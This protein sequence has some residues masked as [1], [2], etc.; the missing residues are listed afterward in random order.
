MR[1]LTDLIALAVPTLL[2]GCKSELPPLE[3]HGE[4]VVVGSDVVDEI[5]AGT[6]ARLD[7]EVM[8]IEDRLDLSHERAPLHVYV[9]SPEAIAAHCDFDNCTIISN[10]DEPFALVNHRSF[11]RVVVHELT[12]ARLAHRRPVPLLE[13]GVAVAM[14]PPQCPVTVPLDL[15]LFELLDKQAT[16]LLALGVGYYIAGEFVAWQLE[17]FGPS[18]FMTF[19]ANVK[20]DSSASALQAKYRAHFD[21]D[22]E[23]DPFA[24]IRTLEDL[25]ELEA[26][27]PENFGCVAPPAPTNG[28]VISLQATLSC[29]S[30]LVQTDFGVAGNG[31]IE[32]TLTLEHVQ[33]FE[34]V[35]SVPEWTSLSLQRCGCVPNRGSVAHLQLQPRPVKQYETLEPGTYRLRWDGAL[36]DELMLD[37]QLVPR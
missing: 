31:F 25:E 19:Y 10:R 37:V 5:C 12:H 23:D 21:R 14:S 1:P 4:R 32:W 36:D 26:L 35:G 27:A 6:L 16:E 15:G 33:T 8:Q 3:F 34:L 9:V 22:I 24:Y 18:S 20:L 13:E 7:R 17:R 30:D 11:E 29:D 2:I 28:K